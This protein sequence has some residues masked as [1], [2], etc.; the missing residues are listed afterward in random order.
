M[1]T[2]RF[3][4]VRSTALIAGVA[5]SVAAL[6]GCGSDDDDV[7][8]EEAFCA[9]GESL[10]SDVTGLANLDIIA[11]GTDALNESVDAIEA[12]LNALQESG[13]EVAS[14]EIEA[15]EGSFDELDD[16]VDALS[17]DITVEN[18]TAIAAAISNVGTSASAFY[19]TLSTTCS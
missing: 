4:K 15:L 2:R 8:P 10:K 16:A 13:S 17:D 12:D 14:D 7:S 5:L 19:E 3:P 11:G 18:S 6:A 9:A 1:T